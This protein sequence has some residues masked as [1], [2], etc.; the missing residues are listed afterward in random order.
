MSF[1]SIDNPKLACV[2]VWHYGFLFIIFVGFG[3][4]VWQ[5]PLLMVNRDSKLI[6]G[7]DTW[8][9]AFSYSPQDFVAGIALAIVAFVAAIFLERVVIELFVRDRCA[10]AVQKRNVLT[11]VNP[12]LE[13]NIRMLRRES[14]RVS[15]V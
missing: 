9:A 12:S 15:A 1:L 14:D 10:F 4:A 11:E 6:N 7:F 8:I 5:F 3:V 2:T 13:R